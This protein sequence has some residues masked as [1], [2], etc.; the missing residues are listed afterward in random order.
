MKILTYDRNV[1]LGAYVYKY[2]LSNNNYVPV[3]AVGEP[4]RGRS[5]GVIPVQLN[6]NFPEEAFGTAVNQCPPKYARSKVKIYDVELTYTATGAPKLKELA[7]GE[8]S[9]A[10]NPAVPAVVVMQAPIG[11]RGANTF[12]GDKI[13]YIYQMN[14]KYS[15]ED[16]R[17]LIHY[18]ISDSYNPGF[19]SE[20]INPQET[21]GI[22][23]IEKKIYQV[24]SLDEVETVRKELSRTLENRAPTMD[25]EEYNRLRQIVEDPEL[26]L[27]QAKYADF[28]GKI[29]VQGQ[30]A[31]GDA[32]R[33]G[34]GSQYIALLNPYDVVRVKYSGRL[35][36]APSTDYLMWDGENLRCC[37][38]QER[39]TFEVIPWNSE[40]VSQKQQWSR[41]LAEKYNN[42]FSQEIPAFPDV[43]FKAKL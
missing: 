13:G 43:N 17:A 5:L 22:Y 32:G 11:F 10:E 39:E 34:S 4:G 31:Q 15:V 12:T 36:G 42:T 41:Y 30:I 1:M 24:T 23:P 40:F 33:M 38:E 16:V 14:H 8:A 3:V 26:Y 9:S 18:W 25:R 21:S 6:Q 7:P 20:I 2:E 27:P 19:K 29:L 37:S 28:P 35:Y